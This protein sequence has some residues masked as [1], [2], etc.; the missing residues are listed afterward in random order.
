MRKSQVSR[1]VTPYRKSDEEEPSV[2]KHYALQEEPPNFENRR[3]FTVCYCVT[4]KQ[5]YDTRCRE[6]YYIRTMLRME[7]ARSK[8]IY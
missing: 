1:G 8:I 2:P 6:H 3:L 7:D 4:C 5:E